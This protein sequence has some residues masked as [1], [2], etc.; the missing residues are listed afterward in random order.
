MRTHE[1]IGRVSETAT[2]FTLIELLV[3][4]A[5]LGILSSLLLPA[6]S[7]GKQRAQSV[8]CVNNGRQMIL[9]LTL[10]AD[11]YNSLFPPNPD[12][13]NSFPGHNW[14]AGNGGEHGQAEFNP[15]ILRDPERSLLTPYLKG[16]ISVF[17]CPGDKRQGLYQGA[18]PALF[19]KT[20]PA[21]RTFSMNQAVGTV[22]EAYDKARGTHSGPPILP[23]NG[24]WLNNDRN[25]R[26]DSPWL[27]YGKLSTIRAPG[28]SKLWVFVD[29]NIRGLNDAAFAYGMARPAWVDGPGTYH[30]GG[31]GFA[32]ADAHS[33]SHRWFSTSEKRGHTW[34]IKNPQD[35]KDWLWM[36]ERTSAHISGTLPPPL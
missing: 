35:L 26:R 30:N 16:N 11:D 3:V 23:V 4:I 17:H 32:F 19:G 20:V 6:L 36:R 14:C 1:H 25:H 21:V 7:R 24:R 13:A 2:G 15:D 27:T 22:C 8:Y 29:E 28:P 10:Y 31:C 18:D 34:Q 33:E 9:A 12:D 5:I